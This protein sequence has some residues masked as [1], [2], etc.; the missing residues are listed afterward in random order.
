MKS[1]TAHTLRKISLFMH[2]TSPRQRVVFM[3]QS[4]RMI[5]ASV[6]CAHNDTHHRRRTYHYSQRREVIIV[7]NT[8]LGP[9]SPSGGKIHRTKLLSL[10]KESENF[11]RPSLGTSKCVQSTQ[12]ECQTGTVPSISSLRGKNEAKDCL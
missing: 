7:C 4:A 10:R 11:T 8:Y 3:H 12:S 5:Y 2:P 1:K 6:M 9:P